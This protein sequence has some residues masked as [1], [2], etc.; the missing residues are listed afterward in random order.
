[1]ITLAVLVPVLALVG[2]GLPAILAVVD[3][4]PAS[5][6]NAAAAFVGGLTGN[7]LSHRRAIETHARECPARARDLPGQ[8]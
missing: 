8:R 6:V 2:P 1:M 3:A 4:A 7:W 5:V